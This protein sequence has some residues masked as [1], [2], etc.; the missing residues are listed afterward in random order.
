MRNRKVWAN[1][2]IVN[3]KMERLIPNEG[4]II[5]LCISKKSKNCNIFRCHLDEFP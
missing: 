5:Q 4:K 2:A 3:K 1:A